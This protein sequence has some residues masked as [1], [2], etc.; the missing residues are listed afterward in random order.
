MDR[1]TGSG[2]F[3]DRIFV[4]ALIFVGLST[5][6][7]LAFLPLRA[8]TTAG[9]PSLLTVGAALIVLLLCGLAIWRAHDVYRLLRRRAQLELV[10]VLIASILLSVVSP[11]RNEL[12]WPACAILMALA[13]LVSPRRALAYCL[14]VLLA[15]LTAHLVSG[16]LP[17]T[18]NVGI[19]GLWIGLPFWTALAA[20]V[21]D[22]MA[23]HILRLNIMQQMLTPPQRVRAWTTEASSE[24]QVPDD[25][26]SA[27]TCTATRSSR[28]NNSDEATPASAVTTTDLIGRLTNRQLQVVALLAD[29]YRYRYIAACLSISPGQVH[30]HVTNAIARLGVHSVNQLVTVAVAEG[31][32][33]AS[34]SPNITSPT[35][36]ASDTEP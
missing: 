7:A 11:L 20:V 9:Q 13:L 8:S 2:Q 19:V 24:P 14:I 26:V 3:Y 35:I 17:T 29:G 27:Q 23:S 28:H 18:S 4:G 12:W 16:D 21:P 34:S 6:A 36:R 25:G 15:N 1:R 10:A 5:L 30:R 31:L 33:P 22:R 32:V